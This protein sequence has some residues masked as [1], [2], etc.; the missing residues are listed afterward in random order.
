MRIYRMPEI[1]PGILNYLQ[2]TNI[3]EMYELAVGAES[4]NYQ[5]AALTLRAWIYANLTV[6]LL[7]IYYTTGM[8]GNGENSPIRCTCEVY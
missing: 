5:A 3:K 4:K 8:S 6:Y 7:P 1:L 2:L